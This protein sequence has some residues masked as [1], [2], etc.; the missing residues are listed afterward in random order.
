MKKDKF[1]IETDSMGDLKVP[2]DA[3]WGAQTQRALD[4][5]CISAT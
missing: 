5:F 4:N 3:K 1:R 2:M